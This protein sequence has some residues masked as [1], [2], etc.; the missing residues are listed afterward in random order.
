MALRHAI[1]SALSRGQSRNGYELNASFKRD[2]DRAWHASP[3]QVYSELTKMAQSGLIEVEER[4]E[5]GRT[6]YVISEAGT[7]ELRRWLIQ[8]E[9]DRSIRDD[10]LM[11]LLSSWVLDDVN[12]SYLIAGEMAFQ[13]KRQIELK[14]ILSTWDSMYEDTR[15]WRTRRAVHELWLKDTNNMLEWLSGLLEAFENPGRPVP[16]I[17]DEK[18]LLDG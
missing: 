7:E 3:S 11:R 5:R 1:L 6:D 2:I 15:V 4:D 9:P 13:R 8:D 10:G 16:E 12:V 14:T 17:F 18:S